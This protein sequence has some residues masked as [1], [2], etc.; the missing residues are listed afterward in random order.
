[1]PKFGTSVP[2]ESV[3]PRNTSPAWI[4]RLVTF[5]I[6][7][8]V[9]TTSAWAQDY[10]LTKSSGLL[11]TRPGNATKLNVST[12][13]TDHL[14][15]VSLPF[16]FHYY[17]RPYSAV[18]AAVAGFVLPGSGHAIV[19]ADS[20]FSNHGQ[21]LTTNAFPYSLNGRTAS[22]GGP[23]YADGIIAPL[24]LRTIRVNDGSV[25]ASA[26][27]TWVVGSAPNRRVIVSWDNV[28]VS[29]STSAVITM[30]VHIHETT[31]RIVFA[32]S[33]GTTGYSNTKYV[34]GIDS[35]LESR[36]TV[37][38]ANSRENIGYPG[39]DFIFDPRVTTFS[40]KLTYDK[41]V[42]DSSGIGNTVS[43]GVPLG[44]L[45]LELRGNGGF[46]SNTTKTAADGTYSVTGYGLDATTNGSITLLARGTA[47]RV[48]SGGTTPTTVEWGAATP[49]LASGSAL[50]TTGLSSSNDA[51]ASLR[52][53]F[54]IVLGCERT[55]AWAAA[56]TPATIPFIDAL[57]DEAGA[58]T[59]SYQSANG[60]A[61][62]FIVVGGKSSPNP[63]AWDDGIVTKLYARHV[64]AVI[65]GAPATAYDD[66]FDAAS[67]AQHAFAEA[68][69][70]ACWSVISGQTT[71]VDATS[72]SAAVVR[73]LEAPV[74]TVARSDAVAGAVTGSLF[75][76]TDAANE[77]HDGFDGTTEQD[78]FVRVVDSMSGAP[79]A[80]SF[81]QAWADAG[82]DAFAITRV[83]VGNG[84][85]PDDGSEPSDTLPEAMS[86]G[87]IGRRRTGF[88]LNRYSEDWFQLTVSESVSSIVA[89]VTW[90]RFTVNAQVLLEIRSGAGTLLATGASI[91][92]TGPVR[93]ST[94]AL[95][96]GS[97]YVRL[98]HE[99]GATIPTYEIQAYKP[100]TISAAPIRDWTA[101]QGYDIPL[102]VDGGVPPYTFTPGAGGL[103]PGIG[104]STANNHGT[105]TPTTAG[106]YGVQL[107]VKDSGTPQNTAIASQ[108]VVIAPPVDVALA[109]FVAFPLGLA[110]DTTLP[111]TGG[112]PPL[113]LDLV[114]GM[115]PEGLAIDGAF[116]VTGTASIAGATPFELEA[117]DVAS[118]TE[119][120]AVRGVVCP[121]GLPKNLL[122]DLAAGDAACGFWID[123]IQGSTLRFSAKTKPKA[124][125]R[126][127]TVTVLGPDRLAIAGLKVKAPLG[128][129][130]CASIPCAK[131]GR[132]YV[133]LSSASGDAT[134]L[135]AAIGAV[136]PKS[137][138]VLFDD[139]APGTAQRSATFGALAGAKV[140]IRVTPAKKSPL[141]AAFT[142]L[143]APDGLVH[144]DG[145]VVK[146][147]GN[148]LTVTATLPDS[149]TWS[150]LF[151]AG[152]VDGEPG[153][154]TV[155]YSL[156]QPKSGAFEADD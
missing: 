38:L 140:T 99:S 93:A 104:I 143:L 103:P 71:C 35:P 37:P 128:G 156:K 46:V 69:G 80:A 98:R 116:R 112:T 24:W 72:S 68:F 114:G 83:H 74:L 27:Y 102:G 120:A 141:K 78:A 64:L 142:A 118:S 106:S 126:A 43:A 6:A 32:Y 134:Q 150:L 25:G 30:Q 94:G 40:G 137:G 97:Y 3:M 36:F 85:L 9:M 2:V 67:T 82:K 123:A 154:I 129:A 149:G 133:I 100:L 138:K 153:D 44:G 131:S 62:A 90:Q 42:S 8:V 14:E 53:A 95:A 145:V 96:A 77:V 152:P 7:L 119:S 59:S 20:N 109:P 13:D 12:L 49:S 52:S 29:A 60:A 79:T 47:A 63:D 5:V 39:N 51:S 22:A 11:E 73:N 31:H 75:D 48:H 23:A 122:V 146:A 10:T 84:V 101:G 107:T 65:A 130:S 108:S 87:E 111:V 66:R 15:P 135:I 81:L 124:V 26:A 4:T 33:T 45:V 121:Q 88:V 136:P 50:G 56:R 105:G 148:G 86:F 147:A 54:N 28:S 61:A 70:F 19:N 132:Y 34:C 55:A 89:D 139:L 17:G 18:D 115:L 16:E 21:D 151:T 57:L 91:G 117:T 41:L 127:L 76:L 58:G 1:M 110:I 144:S 125:K 113:D 92:A 155:S